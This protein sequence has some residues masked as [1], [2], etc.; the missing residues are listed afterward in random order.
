MPAWGAAL[1]YSRVV[2]LWLL[3]RI[4]AL[5]S[6]D[7]RFGETY[8]QR[9]AR[10]IKA[11]PMPRLCRIR[12]VLVRWATKTGSTCCSCRTECVFPHVH[13]NHTADKNRF[14]RSRCVAER[15]S[16]SWILALGR[17]SGRLARGRTST[18]KL[19]ELAGRLWCQ[20]NRLN[21]GTAGGR[22]QSGH[23]EALER[24][25]R[26]EPKRFR[27]SEVAVDDHPEKIGAPRCSIAGAASY[28]CILCYI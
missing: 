12:T 19:P 24:R 8:I 26:S 1:F 4:C 6:S 11:G 7:P 17:N 15:P 10:G 25:I 21:T 27:R 23:L 16:W 14:P 18:P 3:C 13:S 9:R 2:L 5:A 28:C 22:M 20:G